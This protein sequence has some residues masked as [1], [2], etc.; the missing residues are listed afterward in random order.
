MLYTSNQYS[1]IDQLYFKNKFTEK[2]IRFVITRGQ[3]SMGGG[4]R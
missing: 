4:I 3:G 1:I 2:V